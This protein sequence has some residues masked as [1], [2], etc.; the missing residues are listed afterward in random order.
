MIWTNL[1]ASAYRITVEIVSG[2]LF[3]AF[4]LIGGL[5]IIAD[6]GELWVNLLILLGGPALVVL[7][8]GTLAIFIQNNRLLKEIAERTAMEAAPRITPTVAA[9][10]AD[11]RGSVRAEPTVRRK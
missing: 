2:L 10:T 6:N 7:T 11:A 5:R 1:I 8:F 3:L 4:I 9:P